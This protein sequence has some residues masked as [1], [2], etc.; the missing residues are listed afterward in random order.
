LAVLVLTGC[1]L[2]GTPRRSLSELRAALLNRDADRALQ[3]VD[4]DS[5][6]DFAAKDISLRYETKAVR[7]LEIL[8]IEAGKEAAKVLMPGIKALVRKQIRNA[9]T[10]SDQWG[11]FDEIRRASVWYLN[12]T[13]EGDTALVGPK[14]KSDVRFRMARADEG[15]WRIVQI[16]R[17]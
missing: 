17:K 6:V 2:D 3:Y 8:G 1:T 7:P 5:V 14:G 16:F 15:H 9:I 13:V 12:V 10:S 11:Y 4:L